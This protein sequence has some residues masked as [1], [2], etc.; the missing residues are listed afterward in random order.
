MQS[1]VNVSYYFVVISE[2]FLWSLKLLV[3]IEQMSIVRKGNFLAMNFIGYHNLSY[4]RLYWLA[5]S[6]IFF[7]GHNLLLFPS[8]QETLS[9]LGWKLRMSVICLCLLNV[10]TEAASS[11]GRVPGDPWQVECAMLQHVCNELLKFQERAW[12]LWL[13]EAHAV[14]VVHK[15]LGQVRIQVSP[16]L[17][18]VLCWAISLCSSVSRIFIRGPISSLGPYP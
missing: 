10:Q 2:G 13:P 16:A 9:F 1:T 8:S 7:R 3:W 14:D 17:W 18:H 11:G 12:S 6:L 15:G 4:E 5:R